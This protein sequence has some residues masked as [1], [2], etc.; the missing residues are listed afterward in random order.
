MQSVYP[1]QIDLTQ[2]SASKLYVHWCT[3]N[4]KYTAFVLGYNQF[5]LAVV[6]ELLVVAG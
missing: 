1:W 4:S 5:D 3:N 6:Y 2:C